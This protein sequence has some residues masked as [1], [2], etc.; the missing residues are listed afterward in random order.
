MLNRLAQL[1][2]LWALLFSLLAYWQ[3]QWLVAGKDAIVPLLMLIMFG[4]GLSLSWADFQRV[5]KCPGVIGLGV[6]LQ[7][8]LMP[9]IAW[10]IGIAL[11]LPEEL[12]VGLILVGACPGGTASNVIAYL[13]RA[14]V[15]LSVAITFASTL[16]AII[17]TPLLTWLYLGE[18]I[19]VPVLSL[20]H[21]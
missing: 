13:A 1:F 7:Y 16:L 15:A 17:A 14:N 10:G 20:I 6:A 8:S 9:L 11:Q 18:R 21:I 2:P 5:L 3:P 12:L 4:M 19:P